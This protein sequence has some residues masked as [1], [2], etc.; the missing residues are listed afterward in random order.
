M[1]QELKQKEAE[2]EAAREDQIIVNEELDI[3]DD[4][5]TP[6]KEDES[7][8]V[9]LEALQEKQD[10]IERLQDLLDKERDNLKNTQKQ[11][12][13]LNEAVRIAE[14]RTNNAIKERDVFG[15]KIRE[16]IH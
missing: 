4:E 11:V 13:D 12:S 15:D 14:E 8:T 10:E 5:S 9:S 2:L 16:Q 3:L 7:T 6:Q 1:E